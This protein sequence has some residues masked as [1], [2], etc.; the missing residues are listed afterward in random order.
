MQ[1]LALK[2]AG[3]V[4][5]LVGTLHIWRLASKA[6]V[7]FNDFAVPMSW[8]VVGAAAALALSLWMFSASAK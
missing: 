4:F 3:T 6:A 1:K 7:M 8:S 5:L 2:A